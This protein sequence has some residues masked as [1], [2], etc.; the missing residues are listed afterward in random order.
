MQKISFNPA[1]LKIFKRSDAK[2]ATISNSSNPFGMSFKGRVL[3]CDVF[4][5]SQAKE[6]LS[7]TSSINKRS[8]L[9]ASAIAG[10][11]NSA[12][13]YISKSFSGVV[14]SVANISKFVNTISEKLQIDVVDL[15]KSIRFTRNPY[16]GKPVNLLASKLT[17]LNNQLVMT[18][19]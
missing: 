11:Y 2:N 7:F 18:A 4:E 13:N 10:T 5:S 14:D 8:K 16:N 17:E 1:D 6:K 19:V 12:K 9:A 3:N 15:V